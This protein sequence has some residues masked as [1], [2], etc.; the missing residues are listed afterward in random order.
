M[1]LTRFLL[2][3]TVIIWG[4]TF[5][6]TK[7]AL[8]YV[9]PAELL[10]LR[11]LIGLP[12]LLVVIAKKKIRLH[13][14]YHQN[15][16]LLLGSAVITTHFLI[17][18]TGIKYTSAT[19]T[20]WLISVTPLVLA[21]LSYLFLK[22]KIGRN[23]IIGIVV[24]T[25]GIVLLISHG[26]LSHIGWMKSVGDWLV[27]GSAFTWAIYTVA[28]R[29]IS[30]ERNPVA[31]TFAILLPCGVLLLGYMALTS[32]WSRF[33]HLPLEATIAILFLGILGTALAHWFWQE[34]IAKI[35]AAKAG[36]FLYLEPVATTALA[37]PYLGEQFTA[38]TAIGAACVLGGVYWAQRQARR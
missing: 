31:I 36:Y 17:Q 38:I 35:G 15:M 20:G 34:G 10:G 6:A 14:N 8:S 12:I 7:V 23:Q 16:N 11:L 27:L 25:V 37:V 21:V 26:D 4:W 13:F 32:N 29:D 28:T 18:I 24:A 30:R 3:F 9:S 2:L 1:I 19:N 5:V 22:E 33:A